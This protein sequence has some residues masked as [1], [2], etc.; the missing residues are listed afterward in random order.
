MSHLAERKEKNCLN[1][2]TTVVGKYCHVCGQEN[3]EPK[4][5]FWQL[6]S[7]FFANITHFDGKVFTSMKDLI[8][9]PGFLSNEYMSGKRASYLNPIRMYLFTSFVFFL[10]FFSLY[11]VDENTVKIEINKNNIDTRLCIVHKEF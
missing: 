10:V 7:H 6:A 9:R 5:T 2:G 3:V 8:L 11:T 1:C 4:E